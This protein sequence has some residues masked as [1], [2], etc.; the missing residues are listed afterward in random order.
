[1]FD[2]PLDLL[3]PLFEVPQVFDLQLLRQLFILLR[4]ALLILIHPVLN[5]PL[6]L[7]NR[8][9]PFG[10]KLVLLLFLPLFQEALQFEKLMIPLILSGLLDDLEFVRHCV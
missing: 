7:L 5:A 3:E 4:L 6:P 8:L 1:M 2:V 10:V 9:Y